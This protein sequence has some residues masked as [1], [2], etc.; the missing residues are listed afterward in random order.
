MTYSE[1]LQRKEWSFKR[2]EILA[3]DEKV[4]QNCKN[5]K[6]LNHFYLSSI[7]LSFHKEKIVIKGYSYLLKQN[8]QYFSNELT[9]K[10]FIQLISTN[11]NHRTLALFS[12]K[13]E[14]TSQNLVAFL[15]VPKFQDPE[16]PKL[17]KA[18]DVE[19]FS[20]IQNKHVVDFV[21]SCDKTDIKWLICKNLHVHHKYYQIGNQP[22][23]YPNDALV[24]LCWNCHEELHKNEKIP[25]L[26]KE[27]RQIG[28]LT[29][30]PRCFGAGCFPEYN[31]VQNGVCFECNGAK[32]KEFT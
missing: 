5:Q 13:P 3:R 22:W 29:P 30:C 28:N 24:T 32:Y 7:G 10:D 14:N 8:L 18:K 21:K 19:E 4:C 31:H 17:I 9:F 12:Y 11:K 27:N 15:D 1:L 20:I 6:H 23:E 26:D 16:R 2:Q 25:Y